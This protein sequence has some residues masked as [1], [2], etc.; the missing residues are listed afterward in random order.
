M[1]ITE[2][3]K[4]IFDVYHTKDSARGIPQTFVWFI[5]E[6]GE[7]ARALHR[8]QKHELEEE[9]ADC[10]AWLVTLANMT[11]INLE[12]AIRKYQNGC[13]KCHQTPCH[14]SENFGQTPEQK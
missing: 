8:N 6:I 9:F 13:S 7:L 3:Q 11:N 1:H 14:C 5:E 12:D 10:L 2:F 4:L